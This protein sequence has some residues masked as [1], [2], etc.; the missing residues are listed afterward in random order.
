MAQYKVT[1]LTCTDD[2]IYPGKWDS[3]ENY[4]SSLKEAKR[5][6]LLKYWNFFTD[7]DGYFTLDSL[8]LGDD[9]VF[10]YPDKESYI[11]DNKHKDIEK[12]KFYPLPRTQLD[13]EVIMDQYD[14]DD[15]FAMFEDVCTSG[16]SLHPFIFTIHEIKQVFAFST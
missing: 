10:Y 12:I 5:F 1:C 7:S 9:I 2:Y 15:L 8:E 16:D 4:F 13:F 11:R 6:C 3:S 14:L